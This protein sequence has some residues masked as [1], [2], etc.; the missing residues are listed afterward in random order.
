MGENALKE[1][2]SWTTHRNGPSTHAVASLPE[3]KAE[4]VHL[5]FGEFGPN[6]GHIW[7]RSSARPTRE[8][9]KRRSQR[10][11]RHR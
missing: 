9:P 2:V 8:R 1:S 11:W 7:D 5:F 6:V 3:F 10:H 4:A